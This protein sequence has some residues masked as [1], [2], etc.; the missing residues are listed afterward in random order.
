MEQ[1][2]YRPWLYRWGRSPFKG[3][4]HDTN[5]CSSFTRSHDLKF[6]L[7]DNIEID[8]VRRMN[9]ENIKGTT[10]PYAPPEDEGLSLAF[11]GI[12]SASL[13]AWTTLQGFFARGETTPCAGRSEWTSNKAKDKATAIRL[14]GDCVCKAACHEFAE[15]NGETGAV[16]AGVSR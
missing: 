4:Q 5:T 1:V 16:W 11:M 12:P 6:Q 13:D 8:V 2:T 10:R 14:C 15:V 3:Q 9:T 7:V